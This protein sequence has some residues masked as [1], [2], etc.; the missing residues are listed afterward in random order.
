VSSTKRIITNAPLVLHADHNRCLD[1]NKLVDDS[2]W[3]TLLLEYCMIFRTVREEELQEIGQTAIRI[4][5]RTL[6]AIVDYFSAYKLETTVYALSE[7]AQQFPL[8]TTTPHT[9]HKGR[10]RAP[11]SYYK[12]TSPPRSQNTY[13]RAPSPRSVIFGVGVGELG[14]AAEMPVGGSDFVRADHLVA[15]CPPRSVVKWLGYEKRMS[16]GSNR[17]QNLRLLPLLSISSPF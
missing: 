12:A 16:K 1:D 2:T 10:L 15:I 7:M 8:P 9:H 6:S 17:R 14:E 3:R 4:R 5:F 11:P 13:Q